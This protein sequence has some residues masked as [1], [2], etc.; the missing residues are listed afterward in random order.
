MG[1]VLTKALRSVMFDVNY[2]SVER[3]EALDLMLQAEIGGAIKV[4]VSEALKKNNDE[5][6]ELSKKLSLNGT[7]HQLISM[8]GAYSRDSKADVQVDRQCRLELY[9]FVREVTKLGLVESKGLVDKYW[10]TDVYKQ[11]WLRDGPPDLLGM[12]RTMAD[13]LGLSIVRNH[14]F[15]WGVLSCTDGKKETILFNGGCDA[16]YDW[17]S[18]QM[19]AE[20]IDNV[21]FT[22]GVEG[23]ITV[24]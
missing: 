24:K 4:A 17:L 18:E 14:K 22:V 1:S 15:D 19:L 16:M 7:L 12:S 23:V 11:K 20:R 9:G 3:E 8:M 6:V 2:S 5:W 21:A 10:S 13:Y